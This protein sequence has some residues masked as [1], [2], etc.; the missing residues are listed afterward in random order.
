MQ[1]HKA[2]LGYMAGLARLGDRLAF[3]KLVKHFGPRLFSHAYRLLGH[4]EEA[5]DVVQEAWIEIARGLPKLRDDSAFMAWAYR[6]TSRRAARQIDRNI[7]TRAL[8]AGLPE[9]QAAFEDAS[10]VRAAIEH[11]S[12]AQAATIRL[13]YLEEMSLREVA[14]AMD[15]P[16]G[17]VKSRLSSARNQLKPYLE[18]T[19]NAKY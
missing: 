2:Y 3:E 17:T 5:R 18:G 12:P 1:N 13:F 8:G 9:P 11:L 7:K 19:E 14:V 10:S 16:M 15:V 4:R 6:I